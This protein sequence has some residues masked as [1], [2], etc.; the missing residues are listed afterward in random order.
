MPVRHQER[1]QGP[2]VHRGLRLVRPQRARRSQAGRV[3]R[4]CRSKC[5]TST[6]SSRCPWRSI[7]EVARRVEFMLIPELNLGQYA[8]EVRKMA[9][10]WTTVVSMG[11][12][13]G[14][15]ITPREILD[16]VQP[17]SW[18][19]TRAC[20]RPAAKRCG[21]VGPRCAM[22]AGIEKYLHTERLPHIWCPGCGIGT[23]TGA[24]LRAALELDLEAAG[25][26]RGGRHRLLQPGGGLPRLRH[27]ALAIHGR[28]LAFATG[29]KMA[30]PDFTVD[31]AHRRRRRRRH[32]R[33]PP[34]PRLPAQHRH[35]DHPLQQP[36]LRHDRGAGLALQDDGTAVPRLP[37]GTWSPPSTSAV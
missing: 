15:L 2:G 36:D 23:V 7:Q 19:S 20:E 5:S 16:R 25:H 34:D 4:G 35:H 26:R 31:R 6:R 13:D 11:K 10:N 8:R 14:T 3:A 28:A 1:G 12:V 27:R 30:R 33:Q 32:R 22:A 17:S 29:I 21:R 24:F 18:A 37:T 9:E